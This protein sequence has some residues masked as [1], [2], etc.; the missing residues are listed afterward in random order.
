MRGN[1]AVRRIW[2]YRERAATVGQSNWGKKRWESWPTLTEW[3]SAAGRPW[4]MCHWWRRGEMKSCHDEELDELHWT[5]TIIHNSRVLVD[6]FTSAHV[7]MIDIHICT[8]NCPYKNLSRA[9]EQLQLRWQIKKYI[10][11]LPDFALRYLQTGRNQLFAICLPKR[12]AWF[13]TEKVEKQFCSVKCWDQQQ[14]WRFGGWP[15]GK[16]GG[17]Q[18]KPALADEPKKRSKLP[19]FSAPELSF[20]SITKGTEPKKRRYNPNE[21]DDEIMCKPSVLVA[22]IYFNML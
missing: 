21:G 16:L 22:K 18:R 11:I 2:C 13:L 12:F 9:H 5:T 19:F 8:I 15:F 4:Q 17:I 6:W 3:K 20:E 14:G 1:Q 7:K 10:S